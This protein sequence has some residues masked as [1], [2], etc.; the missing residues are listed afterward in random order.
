MSDATILLIVASFLNAL[1]LSS[2]YILLGLGFTFLFNIMGILNFAHGAI[3]MIGAYICFILASAVVSLSNSYGCVRNI[4]GTVRFP[5]L[6]GEHQPDYSC[7]H[8]YYYGSKK[9]R[10]G[11][12]DL[13][14]S[15][16]PSLCARYRQDWNCFAEL[17]TII[18]LF[19]R[20]CSF[21]FSTF[22]HQ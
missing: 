3:Y 11:I 13:Q 19:H 17:G 20:C 9:C 12:T 7:V 2:M 15:D 16:D 22:I 14:C 18:N 21:N 4:A 10:I 1:I 5:P 6:F 8:W